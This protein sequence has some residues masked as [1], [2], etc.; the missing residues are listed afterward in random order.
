MAQ[1]HLQLLRNSTPYADYEAAKAGILNA[2]PSQDGV[3][4]LARYF[5]GEADAEGKRPVRTLLGLVYFKD[6]NRQVTILDAENNID[7]NTINNLIEQYVNNNLNAEDTPVAGQFVTAVTMESGETKV[8]RAAVSANQVSFSEA[9]YTAT[10]VDAAIK[11]L[12]GK[13][14]EGLNE[15]ASATTEQLETLDTDSR[16]TLE[17]PSNLQYVIYQ[18]D[19]ADPANKIGEINIPK[20]TVVSEGEIIT[21]DG[22][23][24]NGTSTAATNANLTAGEKY[25]KLTLANA[26]ETRNLI[27]IAVTDLVDVYA[28]SSGDVVNIL[29]NDYTISASVNDGSITGDKIAQNTISGSNI[30]DGAVGTAKIADGAITEGKI[31]DGAISTDKIADDAIT[32]DKIEAGAVG[33]DQI[34]DSAITEN[35]IENGSIS[36]VKIADGAITEDKIEDGAITTDKIADSAITTDKIADG[37]ITTDKIEDGAITADKLDSTI[38]ANMETYLSGVT[39]NG[40]NG[41]VTDKVAEVTIYTDDLVVGPGA[42]SGSSLVEEGTP[43]NEIL[44]AYEDKIISST[45]GTLRTVKFNNVLSSEESDG[46]VARLRVYGN[47]LT[48]GTGY[49]QPTGDTAYTGV[50]TSDT[51]SAAISKIEQTLVDNMLTGGFGIDIANKI[52]NVKLSGDPSKQTATGNTKSMLEFDDDGGLYVTGIDAGEYSTPNT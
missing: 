26:D 16:V 12:Q 47:D 11:E 15:L 25:V 7:E 6:G 51:V 35:K 41:T 38:T 18:G 28:G 3:P 40:V 13:V 37:A 32:S 22:T 19:P 45:S 44:K 42:P 24:L 20:D 1:K 52:V 46:T 39:V 14:Q 17:N 36:G 31:E 30:A 33:T 49:T 10:T 23:E 8:E 34:A 43:L 21:A 50:L 27:Y 29:V 9:D 2:A 4:V 5:Y 48:V